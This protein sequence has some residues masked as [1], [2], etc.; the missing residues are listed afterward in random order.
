MAFIASFAGVPLNLAGA[1]DP[2]PPADIEA[3][4]EKMDT[5]RQGWPG[6]PLASAAF[7]A[8]PRSRKP[9]LGTLFDP[10]GAGRHA[11]AYFLATQQ[12]LDAIR[13]VLDALKGGSGQ[14]NLT[15]GG[16]SVPTADSAGSRP[17]GDY[18][19]QPLRLETAQGYV[20][21]SMRMLPPKPIAGLDSA[22]LYVLTFVDWRYDAAHIILD[23]LADVDETGF[24]ANVDWDMLFAV[25]DTGYLWPNDDDDAERIRAHA[26]VLAPAQTLWGG[27][28]NLTA[29]IEAVCATVGLRHNGYNLVDYQLAESTIDSNRQL[30]KRMAGG[31][32]PWRPE[33][34]STNITLAEYLPQWVMVGFTSESG[35]TVTFQATISGGLAPPKYY[36]STGFVCGCE[37]GS[38]ASCATGSVM[39]GHPSWGG[40]SLPTVENAA[41]IGSYVQQFA[42]DLKAWATIATMDV[43]CP[44]IVA[45]E[46]DGVHD[47]EWTYRGDKTTTRVFRAPFQDGTDLVHVTACDLT[48]QILTTIKCITPKIVGITSTLQ[49]AA[50]DVSLGTN[51]RILYLNKLTPAPSDVYL[52]VT[53]I[54]NAPYFVKD[55][56]GN[57]ATYNATVYPSSGTID[58]D[59]SFVMNTD[60]QSAI[61]VFDGTDWNLF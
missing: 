19:Y 4:M 41:E 14:V 2:K 30:I 40:G 9:K 28:Q 56:A 6:S 45:L 24:V 25:L 20:E 1:N 43:T 60:K 5:L 39:S 57:A 7:G 13:K 46:P 32:Y 59:A 18:L 3:V 44:G 8:Q 51:D 58:G 29:V 16:A 15:T 48:G 10:A 61:F 52:P 11:V 47:F 37:S 35:G 50:G 53:P 17:P 38:G 36:R 27:G 34:T 55:K 23:S 49:T 54:V 31:E 12:R 42:E 22:K 26:D 33:D 21:R